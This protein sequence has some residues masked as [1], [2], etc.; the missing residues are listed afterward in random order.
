MPCSDRVSFLGART[1]ARRL[2][3]LADV[4]VHPGRGEGFGLA[5]VEAML[6]RKPV[7]VAQDGALPEYVHDN[8][9]GL[10]FP[11]GDA[12]AL[13]R[14]ILFIRDNP[15]HGAV[16]GEA[17]RRHCLRMFSPSHFAD[18]VTRLIEQVVSP[19]GVD[20]SVAD[21]EVKTSV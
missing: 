9:T 16:L 18:S 19:G 10:L 8:R 2:L 7:I 12:E 15:S 5:V 4:C 20:A 6:A 11:P 21:V 17:G 1:D 3:G 13:A 14:Q